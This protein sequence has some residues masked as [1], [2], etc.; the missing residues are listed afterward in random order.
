M[1]RIEMRDEIRAMAEISGTGTA[2]GLI[3]NAI[4]D[5]L[6]NITSLAR[7]DELYTIDTVLNIAAN[8]VVTLPSD[9]QH[10]DDTGI[11]FLRDGEAENRIRLNPYH[12]VRSYL[13]GLPKQWRYYGTDSSGVITRKLQITPYAEIV[14]ADDK[15]SIS[16]WRKYNWDT[17]TVEFPIPKFEETIKLK[18][19]ARIAKSK[20]SRLSQKLM[21]QSKEAYISLRAGVY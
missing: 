11:Y 5:A 20:D 1:L 6:N 4:Q 7:Y 18:V 2:N 14:T 15:L 3:N 19:A 10:L 9:F 17:D 21:L 8:G 16:Y 12:R 13:T